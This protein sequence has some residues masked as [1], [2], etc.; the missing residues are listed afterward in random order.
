MN[1]TDLR[2]IR[3]KQ[4]LKDGLCALLMEKS[5]NDISVRELC[6][7]TGLNRGTF[8]LHYKN[9]RALT[10]S[11]EDEFF[12]NFIS[13][14]IS[15][16]SDNVKKT[17]Y[18]ILNGICDF[19]YKNKEL[20]KI[21]LSDKADKQFIIKFKKTFKEN[22]EHIFLKAY[23]IERSKE[24]DFYYSYFSN[25]FAG[26]LDFWFEHPELNLRPQDIAARIE[27]LF[28]NGISGIKQLKKQ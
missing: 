8:Y 11:I 4:I 28:T 9:I 19:F 20:C 25:G 2:V 24:F 13:A 10:E 5:L 18:L 3:T 23:N 21:F 17:P 16:S 1:N 15:P 26:I 6:E 27:A 12:D 22:S 14:V 7:F